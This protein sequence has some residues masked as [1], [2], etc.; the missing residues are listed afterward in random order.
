MLELE[1]NSNIYHLQYL[2]F[3]FNIFS[4]N[5][6]TTLNSV[7]LILEHRHSSI[8]LNIIRPVQL[9]F[10][11]S[12]SKVGNL[13]LLHGEIV[14]QLIVVEFRYSNVILSFFIEAISISYI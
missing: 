12:V 8:L 4:L 2:V 5:H 3:K 6:S 13:V 1:Y 7:I 14:L 11:N 9:F 10:Y